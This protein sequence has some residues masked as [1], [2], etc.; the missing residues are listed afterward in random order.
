MKENR[1]QLTISLLVSNRIETI[2]RCLDSLCAIMEAIP[3]E[4]ILVDT[5]KNTEIHQLLLEYTDKVY[6]FEWCNDFAKARNEGLKRATGEWFMFLDDDE[7]FADSK[8]L[9]EFFKSGEYRQYGYANYQVRN[10]RDA[11]YIYYDDC[12]LMRMIRIDEDTRF[13]SKIH[14]HFAP[15]RGSKKIFR[16]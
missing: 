16:H 3:C 1:P 5:S 14:E 10:F 2:P 7:W 12:W 15:I 9:I 4:L 13:V 8:A 11:E 6:T